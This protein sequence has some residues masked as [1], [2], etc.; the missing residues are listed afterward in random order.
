MVHSDIVN[1]WSTF[2]IFCDPLESMGIGKPSPVD[3]LWMYVSCPC[4][5]APL[6]CIMLILACLTGSDFTMCTYSRYSSTVQTRGVWR[7]L[8]VDESMLS[9][10]GASVISCVFHIQHTSPTTKSDAG[11]ANHQPLALSRQDGCVCSDTRP[12]AR[13]LSQGGLTYQSEAGLT[14]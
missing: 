7:P 1:K 2:Q 11:P 12:V 4:W 14:R 10:S 5:R 9:T 8:P 3:H 13:N 6:Y